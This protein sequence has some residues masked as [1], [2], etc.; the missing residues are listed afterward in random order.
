MIAESS[1]RWIIADQ[2]SM[3]AGG[4][5]AVRGSTAPAEELAYIVS[6]AECAGLIVHD[7]AAL[8]NL[9]PQLSKVG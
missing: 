7:A 4:S 3:M 2:A 6:H 5:T 9:A 1:S 8:R